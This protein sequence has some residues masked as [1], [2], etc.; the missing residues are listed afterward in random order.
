MR[1]KHSGLRTIATLGS[2]LM[3]VSALPGRFGAWSIF[4]LV[5]VVLFSVVAAQL[6]WS[7]LLTWSTSVPLLGTRLNTTGVGEL[8][9]HLFALLVMLAGAYAMQQD[10]HIRVDVLS[11]RF[12][13]RMRTTMDL[14]GDLFL[15][16]PFFGCLF[17]FSLDF[18]ARA[19]NFGEQS[20]NGG[21]IDRY[22]VK[23]MLTVGCV[24]ML[25]CAIGRILRNVAFLIA[26]SL[27]L[28][29]QNQ[30][31]TTADGTEERA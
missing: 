5:L 13:P 22:L 31:T 19:Y 21:L 7:E 9:W 27:E 29:L 8:Q 1:K 10:Q 16:L 24:L 4:V 23:S 12:S 28:E 20:N 14:C 18:V 25:L 6:S 30:A 17:W 15:L 26:P 2:V 11:S 3:R